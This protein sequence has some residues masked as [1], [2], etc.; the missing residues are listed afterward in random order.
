VR[1]VH[2]LDCSN[3]NAVLSKR[4]GVLVL[5]AALAQER[6]AAAASAAAGEQP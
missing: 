1:C 3:Y 5:Q 6:G 4:A 2:H